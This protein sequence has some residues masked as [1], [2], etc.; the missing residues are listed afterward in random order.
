MIIFL[1]LCYDPYSMLHDVFIFI[2]KLDTISDSVCD[3]E[4]QTE[5]ENEP[6]AS[7]SDDD[8]SESLSCAAKKSGEYLSIFYFLF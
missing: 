3:Q 7:S 4:P 1:V 5:I 2:S 6:Y 8:Q